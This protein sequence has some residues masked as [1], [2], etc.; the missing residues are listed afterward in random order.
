MTNQQI[1]EMSVALYN[2]T[3]VGYVDT[4]DVSVAMEI[5]RLNV[6]SELFKSRFRYVL[7]TVIRIIYP[8][9]LLY[10]G[11][12]DIEFSAVGEALPELDDDFLLGERFVV[13]AATLCGYL[14]LDSKEHYSLFADE[15]GKIKSEIP[16]KISSLSDVYGAQLA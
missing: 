14:M 4:K 16:A 2:G 6:Q 5:T 11:A 13:A 1:L 9:Y 10:C 15:L 3:I 12:N 7:S 8:T